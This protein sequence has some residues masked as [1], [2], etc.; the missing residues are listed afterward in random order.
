MLR[1]DRGQALDL[2]LV[3]AFDWHAC[4]EVPELKTAPLF[5][6]AV[7]AG[8]LYA[9]LGMNE[10]AL[11]RGFGR[12]FGVAFQT[13][14]DLLE[15]DRASRCV[16]EEKLTTLRAA[17]AAFGPARHELEELIDYLHARVSTRQQG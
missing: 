8:F 4:D 2:R 6:L 7:S 5:M 10:K 13:A 16:F 17:V 12:D 1:A 14:D 15:G 3:D 9:D 11:L